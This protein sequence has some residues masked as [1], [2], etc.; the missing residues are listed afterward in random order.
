[1]RKR[2]IELLTKDRAEFTEDEKKE[3]EQIRRKFRRSA[4]RFGNFELD[5]DLRRAMRRE[6]ELV[7]ETILREDRPLTELLES[8]YTFLNE[9]L[10]KHYGIEDVTGDEMRMVKLPEESPRGGILTQGTMLA[11]TSNPDRTSPVKRGLYILD[12]ILGTPPPPPPP[13]I[14]ALEDA[15]DEHQ[16]LTLTVREALAIHREQPLCSSCHNR[17]DPLGLAMERFNALGMWRETDHGKPIETVGELIT[18]EEFSDIN[19]LKHLLATN[20]RQEFYRC[21]TEKLLIYALGRGIE[22][23]DTE[24]VDAIVAELE[25]NEGRPSVL[26]K[27]IVNSA[28]FQKCRADDNGSNSTVK[29]A[30]VTTTV[31]QP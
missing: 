10:A 24:T 18:G 2:F 29:T 20:H 7:F 4:D 11:V 19:E 31:A 21:L 16:K 13:N 8:D 12:N 15:G 1:M 23:H 25:Q 5:G 3:F 28:A 6:T 17:M 22:Y 9:D 30:S 27:G 14:P 26:L